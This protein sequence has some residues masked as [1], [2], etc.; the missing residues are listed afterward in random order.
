MV[1]N[2]EPGQMKIALIGKFRADNGL[3]IANREIEKSLR[4]FCEI[5]GS[6]ETEGIRWIRGLSSLIRRCDVLVICSAAYLNC[7]AVRLAKK[8][9]KKTIYIM[10]GLSSYEQAI[11]S[12]QSGRLTAYG[13][14]RYERYM[15]KQADRII[16][17]SE[18]FMNMVRERFPACAEKFGW[19]NNVVDTERCA[20]A[21]RTNRARVP[22]TVLSTGGGKR[23][24]NIATLASAMEK[25]GSGYILHV[26]GAEASEGGEIRRRENIVWHGCLPHADLLALMAKTSVY[27]QNSTFESFGLSVVEALFCGCSILVSE[28]TGCLPLFSGLREEDVIRDVG[29]TEEIGRKIR[30]LMEHPNNVRLQSGFSAESVTT[31]RQAARLRVI[32]GAQ[33]GVTGKREADT[34]EDGN[35]FRAK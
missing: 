17:V 1:G 23:Q 21:C 8:H 30:Y 20:E 5:V 29:D 7:L 27:V 12:R 32:I 33:D 14:H 15:M 9:R 10:H 16:C 34:Y 3:G 24:K 35:C 6:R 2:G 13:I 28:G 25:E 31:A 19:I 18:R 4:T 11:E 22:G 26:A